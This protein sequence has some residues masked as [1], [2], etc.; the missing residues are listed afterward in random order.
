MHSCLLHRQIHFHLSLGGATILQKQSSPFSSTDVRSLS[1]I[2]V[3]TAVDV[4]ESIANNVTQF[5]RNRL[6]QTKRGT[7]SSFHAKNQKQRSGVQRLA[8]L[9]IDAVIAGKTVAST[10]G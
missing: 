10:V 5:I 7:S 8:Q 3:K 6:P 9:A 4:G 2:V 1:D